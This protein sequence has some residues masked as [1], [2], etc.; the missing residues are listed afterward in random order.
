M[1]Q[2]LKAELQAVVWTGGSA[3]KVFGDDGVKVFSGVPTEDQFPD[4]FPFCVV[5]LDSGVHDGDHP[6][7][8]FHGFNVIGCVNTV[9]DQLGEFAMIGGSVEELG[10]SVGRGILEI[11][12]RIRSAVQNLLGSDGAKI[13][14]SAS[15]VGSPGLMGAGRHLAYSS[16]RVDA[17][18]TSELH[19]A[20]PQEIVINAGDITWV[21]AHCSDRFDFLQYRV[22][23]KTGTA[24]S[25][26]PS[27]GTL[28]YTGTAAT[29]SIVAASNVTYTAFADYN[30]RGGSSIDGSSNPEIGSHAYSA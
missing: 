1:S 10:K 30:A 26:S 6:E 17:W 5:G 13:M 28:Q 19:Y 23:A 21:G 3:E 27:D 18:C 9:G 25:T 22:F 16:L 20:S 15:S 7:L 11:D 14:L 4:G 29:F 8:I 24:H 2:Q 12:E